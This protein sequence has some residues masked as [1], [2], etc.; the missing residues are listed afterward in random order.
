[1]TDGS[2]LEHLHTH[3]I[4][5]DK[6]ILTQNSLFLINEFYQKDFLLFDYKMRKK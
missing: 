6:S 1:V 2:C 3:N 4:K 5:N